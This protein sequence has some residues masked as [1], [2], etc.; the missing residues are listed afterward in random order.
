MKECDP[1]WAKSWFSPILLKSSV[2]KLDK[3]QALIKLDQNEAS[4]DWPFELKDEILA[5]LKEIPWNL[6]PRPF[7]EDLYQALADSLGVSQK[8][9]LC[10]DGSNYMISTL[11]DA[12]TQT[13][14]PVI[15]P[16]PSFPLF[17]EFLTLHEKQSIAWPLDAN[18]GFDL[19]AFPKRDKFV[20]IL[21]L[22]NNPTGTAL[23]LD[24]LKA[25]L[26]QHP[27]GLFIIDE[28]YCGFCRF[29]YQSLLKDHSNMILLRTFSKAYAAAGL[30]F[31]YAVGPEALIQEVKKLLHPYNLNIF[32]TCAIKN[33]CSNPKFLRFFQK[34]NKETVAERERFFGEL[35]KI[36]GLTTYPSES[37]FLL[38]KAS[39]DELFQS[40]KDRIE[41][42]QI[43]VRDVSR[44]P[45][46]E[47]CLRI[48]VGSREDN[49]RCLA[50]FK[51]FR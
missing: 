36:T 2:Y 43:Q 50:C 24:D 38:V 17:R 30:R 3:S 7:D 31:G 9:I 33:L 1:Q 32:T 10:G 21:D 26:T 28:A 12:F 46:L 34:Q 22:P 16:E 15:Y 5:E 4:F 23:S 18:F 44:G 51:I 41:H 11:L 45:R 47:R 20:A 48:S 42:A 13:D 8:N 6:Y 35:K 14:T 25:L 27:H 40:F 39:D 29:D 19:T 49:T 37:N